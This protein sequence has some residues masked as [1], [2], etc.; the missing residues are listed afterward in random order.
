MFE[1]DLKPCFKHFSDAIFVAYTRQYLGAEGANGKGSGFN[2]G[3]SYDPY[4]GCMC[5][6]SFRIHAE[7]ADLQPVLSKIC[8]KRGS[9]SIPL[10]NSTTK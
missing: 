4:A 2:N 7:D 8:A 1:S 10:E 6:L 3:F 5:L 9:R